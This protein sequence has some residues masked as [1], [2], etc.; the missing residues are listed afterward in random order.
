M[1]R[2]YQ[3]II[4]LSL[5]CAMALSGCSTA[6]QET[7][8]ETVTQTTNAIDESNNQKTAYTFVDQADNEVTVQI[9]VDRMVVMQHH[10]LDILAQLGA[11]EKVVATEKNWEKDLGDYMK[12]VFPNIE[13]L[14]TPGDL[15][16]WNVEEIVKLN[17]DVVIAASQANP[18]TIQQLKELK[19]PVVV[20][21]LRGEGK[22]EEAQNPRLSDA[23][24]AYTEG[25]EWAVKT[26]GK[27]TGTEEKANQIWDFCLESRDIVEKAVGTIKEEDRVRV[28]IANE[29][30]QTYGNDK[31]VGSQLLRAGAINVASK[32]IQG[33]QPYTFEKLA[34]WN[35]DVII[36]QD[37]YEEVYDEIMT[38]AKYKELKA[39]KEGNVLLAPYWTKPW[40]N[41]DTDSIAL[42][43]LWLAHQFYP[44][45]ISK[46]IVQER[47]KTFYES[48]YGVPFTGEV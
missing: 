22:Q 28:F 29:G 27:L 19:I 23:D 12:D 17:P 37:R 15:Q 25:C 10:S 9:P 48:F 45:K 47:A 4:S 1:K 30:Q 6:K 46:E 36:V 20:V 18:D 2:I 5:L 8:T 16:E 39:V 43:E 35:P 40:G 38:D 32:E 26:L 34:Q 24:S 41:P 44:D 7:T 14:P 33:Y 42:G 3:K 31:Y 21:S 13:S 11:Q